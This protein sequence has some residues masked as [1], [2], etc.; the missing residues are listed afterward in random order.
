MLLQHCT[1]EKVACTTG[2]IMRLHPIVGGR[3][4]LASKSACADI[5]YV[6]VHVLVNQDTIWVLLLKLTPGTKNFHE[7]EISGSV[8]SAKI[9]F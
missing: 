5:S 9:C 4:S 3:I 2:S 7:A 8:R 6:L 1:L